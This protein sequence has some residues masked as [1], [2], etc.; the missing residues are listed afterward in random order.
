MNYRNTLLAAATAAV[1]SLPA[2]AGASGFDVQLNI[3]PPPVQ[4]EVAPAPRPGYVWAQGYRDYDGHR[5]VWRK[6]HW[7]HEH[8]GEHWADS[9][10]VEHNGH[11]ELH[12]GHWE[13]G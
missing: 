10:W 4:Y 9:R 7:E 2:A 13:R 11:W 5:H 1:L 8:H 6:G 12:R 3:G